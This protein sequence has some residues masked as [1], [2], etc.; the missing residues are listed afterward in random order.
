MRMVQLFTCP[1]PGC[2]KFVKFRVGNGHTN[3]F[4]HLTACF[5]LE[6]VH[7]LYNEAKE[8]ENQAAIDGEVPGSVRSHFAYA[9]ANERDLTIYSWLLAIILQN[10]PLSSVENEEMRAF[11]KYNE[12][13]ISIKTIVAVMFA[14]VELVEEAIAEELKKTNCGALKHDGWSR[15]GIH[16]ISLFACYMLP[17]LVRK[18]SAIVTEYKRMCTLLAVSPMSGVLEAG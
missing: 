12:H 9:C 7:E 18:K 3:C 15:N 17:L 14:L 4:T 11:S 8:K 2:R 5:G 16:Y 1:K 10:L 6:K 13:P